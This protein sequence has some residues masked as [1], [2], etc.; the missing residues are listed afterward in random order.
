VA[1]PRVVLFLPARV[2]PTNGDLPAADLQPLELIHIASPAEQA[3]YEVVVIDAMTEENYLQQVL[4]ACDGAMAYGSSCILG[5][6]VYDGH[7]VAQAVRQ[8]YPKLPM[9]WGGWFPMSAPELYLSSDICDALC[10]GQG[11]LT[12]VEMLN[13]I[14]AGS[15]WEKRLESVAGLALWRDGQVMYTPRRPVVHLNDVPGPSFHLIDLQ[16]YYELNK[17]TASVGH[18]IRNRLPPPPPFDKP[19]HPYRGLSYFSSF[20]C[21]EPCAFC[22]SP[23]LAGR[24]WVALDPI[25][26]VDRIKEIY[27]KDPFDIL[28]LQDANFGVAQKRT[29]VF[30]E[31]LIESGMNIQWNGTVEIKQICQYTDESLDLLKKSGCHLLWFGAEASTEETQDLIRKHIRAGQTDTAMKRVNDRG[32][33]AGM[34]YII[35]YPGE[36]EESMLATIN[37]AAEMK[38][39]YPFS[40]AEVFPYRPLPGSEFWQASL[41]AGYVAPKTF[42]DWGRFFD[43]KFNSYWG[44]VPENVQKVFW[45][46]NY[47]SPWSD[48]HSGGRGPIS[49]LLRR[50]ANWRLRNK[51]Y[52]APFE[53]KMYDIVRRIVGDKRALAL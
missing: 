26:M 3:G 49:K 44:K 6:Q 39:K 5:Y 35:G 4:D 32:I 10:M 31:H 36:T 34:S 29:K 16:K 47:L 37:E 18:R 48:G 27:K 25:V 46:Y 14:Q 19:D 8:K 20:G 9:L 45:R 13:A 41:D 1:K 40:T 2:D 17:R 12:F 33:K 28:R 15:G 22:C 24:R 42:E 43:Y 11:E 51:K 23:E 7:M 50:S 30:C 53:F 52:K 21:P 38:T